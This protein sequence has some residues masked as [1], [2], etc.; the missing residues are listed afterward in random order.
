VEIRLD[1]KTGIAVPSL[2]FFENSQSSVRVGRAFHID[3]NA[4]LHGRSRAGNFMGQGKAQ[5]A[6]EIQPELRQFYGDISVDSCIAQRPEYLHVT[7]A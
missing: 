7:V 2:Y 5:S 3:L 6:I 4:C 1:G